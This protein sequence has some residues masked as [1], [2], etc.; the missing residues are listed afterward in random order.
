MAR[1]QKYFNN[2]KAQIRSYQPKLKNR[3]E[4]DSLINGAYQTFMLLGL[5]ALRDEFD[6]GKG[7]LQRYIDKVNDLLDSYNKGYVSI[8]DLYDTFEK[9]TGINVH[10]L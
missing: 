8:D 4:A 9:E 3:R 1:Q 7:R 10:K 2:S 5:W 6:F